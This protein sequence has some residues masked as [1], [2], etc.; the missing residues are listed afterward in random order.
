MPYIP[1]CPSKTPKID[2]LKKLI[3]ERDTLK[4]ESKN[5][6]DKLNK[7]LRKQMKIINIFMKLS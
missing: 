6:L 4:K 7:L 3:V 1:P 2:E 5:N